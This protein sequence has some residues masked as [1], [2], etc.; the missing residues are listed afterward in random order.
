M[1][2]LLAIAV[3]TASAACMDTTPTE[4]I[5]AGVGGDYA[6]QSM[7]GG[8][9]PLTFVSADTTQ[10]VDSDSISLGVTG[11][12]IEVIHYRETIG[13]GP[14][15]D[16]QVAIDGTWTRIGNSVKLYTGGGLGYFGA[17]A[18]DSLKL[19]DGGNVFVFT[20]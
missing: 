14:T 12:W 5:V 13:G 17:V 8:A 7:N 15:N 18:P 4:P 9:L 1:R 19:T 2:Q 3:L 6:L 11:T 16:L 10:I 20:H